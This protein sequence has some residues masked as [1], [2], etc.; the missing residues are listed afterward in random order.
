MQAY[1]ICVGFTLFVM[2]FTPSAPSTRRRHS[3]VVIEATQ[4]PPSSS[5][6]MP[7]GRAPEGSLAQMRRFDKDPLSCDTSKAVSWPAN[8]SATISVPPSGV[9]T[10]PF[11]NVRPVATTLAF[12]QGS[13]QM[14]SA[15]F[16]LGQPVSKYNN[17]KGFSQIECKLKP[18]FP[19][20][21]RPLLST[22]M[23]LQ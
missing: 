17:S 15:D 9:I 21:A 11:G 20:Y 10:V 23:S 2:P 22:T 19:T 4:I 18:K 12:P 8:V 1:G 5:R 3:P 7:S 13:T 14:S 6:H 16:G